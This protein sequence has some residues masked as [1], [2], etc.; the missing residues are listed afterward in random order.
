MMN[1]ADTARI[2]ELC[3]LIAQEQDRHKFLE[4]VEEM[5]RSLDTKDLRLKGNQ[6]GTLERVVSSRNSIGRKFS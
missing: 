3:S 4:L 2:R 6:I 1:E 5:N